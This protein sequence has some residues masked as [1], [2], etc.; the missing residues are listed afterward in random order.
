MDKIVIPD[1]HPT[2]V[3]TSIYELSSAEVKTVSGG[4]YWGGYPNI[5]IASFHDSVNSPS[6]TYEGAGNFHDNKINTVDYSRSSYFWI[7]R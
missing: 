2:D 5:H 3:D 4:I 6:T 1:L 7:Y